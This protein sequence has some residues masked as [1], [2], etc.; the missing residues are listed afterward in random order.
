MKLK[1]FFLSF[2]IILSTAFAFSQ[3]TGQDVFSQKSNQA[4]GEDA[5][6][7]TDMP[8]KTYKG[9]PIFSYNNLAKLHQMKKD[10]K[11]PKLSSGELYDIFNSISEKY[12][13][14]TLMKDKKLKELEYSPIIITGFIERVEK[15]Y[16]TNNYEVSLSVPRKWAL[17]DLKIEYS[18]NI[19][20][21]MV[22]ELMLLKKG[23]YFETLVLTSDI[24]TVVYVPV[25]NSNGTLRTE[26]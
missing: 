21:A 25:W 19:S 3:G 5:L 26:P 15:N 23:D 13:G 14:N 1:L 16:L 18:S 17:L 24:Y 10:N 8:F 12:S 6:E 9:V 22:N 20:P 2:L 11:I 4:K 7:K